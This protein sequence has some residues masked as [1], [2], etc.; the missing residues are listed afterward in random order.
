MIKEVWRPTHHPD[1]DVSNLGRVRSRAPQG[2]DVRRGNPSRPETP[3]ILRPGKASTGYWT[4]AFG[5]G[6]GSQQVHRLVAAAFIGP[7]PSEQ[8]CRHKDDD[9]SNACVS[10][11][12]Y[13]TRK[14]NVADM[15][16]R[17]RR[18][19]KLSPGKV[20]SIRFYLARPYTQKQIAKIFGV[21]RMTINKVA[22]G[23]SWA[24]V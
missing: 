14:Q 7:C 20:E 8:E 18:S 3:R 13:G 11:L 2:G 15:L 19:Y 23:K 24:H 12:E 22:T 6:H 16:R 4:V 17:N 10:N 1:Y 5:R 9:R 21:C